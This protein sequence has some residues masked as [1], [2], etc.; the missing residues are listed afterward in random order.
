MDNERQK[1]TF[2]E[3]WTQLGDDEAVLFGLTAAH[4]S[5]RRAANAEEER[6]YEAMAA[7]Q[8]VVP[9]VDSSAEGGPADGNPSNERIYRVPEDLLAAYN[10][11]WSE[12]LEALRQQRLWMGKC[13]QIAGALYGGMTWGVLLKLYRRRFRDA[14]AAEV[15]EVFRRMPVERRGFTESGARLIRDDLLADGTFDTYAVE[16]QRNKPFYIPNR[17]EIEE[18]HAEGCLL[19]S[20]ECG[21]MKLFLIRTFQYG[22]DAAKGALLRLSDGIRR[23]EAPDEDAF[24]FPSR[25]ARKDFRKL[26]DEL[27]DGTRLMANRGHTNQEL[28]DRQ[29]RIRRSIR[30]NRR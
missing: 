25:A 2:E 3:L 1:I 9:V 6:L 4:P 24:D 11:D 27:C 16:V 15:Q 29:E 22:E 12:D 30:R 13:L 21:A 7:R 5:G 10:E 17:A 18:F 8:L 26:Y 20:R 28:R 19:N 23:G 14:G